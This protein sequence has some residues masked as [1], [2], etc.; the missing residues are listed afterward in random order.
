MYP[1]QSSYEGGWVADKRAGE[2]VY[3]YANGD[4]YK[5]GWEADVKS[6]LGSYFFKDSKSTFMGTW[7]NGLLEDGEWYAPTHCL[8]SSRPL[9]GVESPV[10]TTRRAW[11]CLAQWRVLRVR[12]QAHLMQTGPWRV[13]GSKG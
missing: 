8:T 9:A 3:K 11:A 2:G 4:V 1:D 12:S 10:G 7:V 5:G 13:R 6:G